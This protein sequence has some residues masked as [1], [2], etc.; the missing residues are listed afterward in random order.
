MNTECFKSVYYE[1]T[2]KE[3]L[4]KIDAAKK[5][6]SEVPG[7]LPCTITKEFS[8][9]LSVPLCSI[10]NNIFKSAVWPKHWKKEYVTPLGKI[11]GI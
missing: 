9:E 11:W 8:E 7:D 2:V 6:R 10:L 5:P 3:T 1:V 4:E